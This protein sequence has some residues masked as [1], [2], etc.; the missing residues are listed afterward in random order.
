MGILQGLALT[1]AAAGELGVISSAV[2]GILDLSLESFFRS[3]LEAAARVEPLEQVIGYLSG[4]SGR[5]KAVP[6]LPAV[7]GWAFPL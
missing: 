6:R 1:A 3:D 7:P 4:F 5:I 2:S